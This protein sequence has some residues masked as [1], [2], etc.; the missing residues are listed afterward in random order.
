MF[1][2]ILT[3][4]FLSTALIASSGCITIKVQPEP[5]KV[6]VRERLPE[7]PLAEK[8]TLDNIAGTEMTPYKAAAEHAAKILK[9]NKELKKKMAV[10]VSNERSGRTKIKGNFD[11]LIRWGKKNAA[12]VESYNKYAKAHNE[13]DGVPKKSEEE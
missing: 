13:Q 2:T 4:A 11:K 12:T 10:A 7:Y 5:E 8:P 3:A 9:D 1:R 6:L